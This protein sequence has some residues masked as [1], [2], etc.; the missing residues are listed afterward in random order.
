MSDIG[1]NTGIS[2][3][4]LRTI[5]ER[6]ERLEADKDAV[7][8]DIKALYAEVKGDGFDVK[9]I[10]NIVRLRKMDAT[11]RDEQQALLD[12]YMSALGDFINTEL[13]QAGKP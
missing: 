12:I 2:G 6:V 4:R 8:E 13:G 5:I 11:K 9:T 3:E 1:H 7:A 10:R